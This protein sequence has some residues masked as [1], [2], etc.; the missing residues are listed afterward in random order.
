VTDMEISAFL[1]GPRNPEH[2]TLLRLIGG[3]ILNPHGAEAEDEAPAENAGRE[4]SDGELNEL[5]NMLVRG[6]SIEEIARRLR[7]DHGDVRDKVAEV[8]QACR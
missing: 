8:G 3:S 5:G 6:L 1:S 7:R 2:E 4:W